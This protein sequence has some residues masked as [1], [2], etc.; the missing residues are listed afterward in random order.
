[1]EF[2][3]CVA[4]HG[5]SEVKADYL[6]VQLYARLINIAFIPSAAAGILLQAA[7]PDL[8]CDSS[9][10]KLSVKGGFLRVCLSRLVG[11]TFFNPLVSNVLP[12]CGFMMCF[13]LPSAAERF[14]S[15]PFLRV[16]TVFC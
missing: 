5:F 4:V 10:C 13:L 14:A 16:A 8:R 1:M 3:K 12:S 6:L 11:S 7:G 15:L 9:C 2:N